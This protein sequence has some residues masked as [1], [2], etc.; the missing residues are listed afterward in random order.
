MGVPGQASGAH[1]GTAGGVN[2]GQLHP[3]DR[4]TAIAE[5]VVYRRV[6][7]YPPFANLAEDN[8]IAYQ[9]RFR[10]L[11][12]A[13]A[14]AATLP[15]Q[16]MPFSQPTI[17]I[18]RTAA[19]FRTDDVGLPVGRN[20]LDIFAAFFVR[21]GGNDSIDG[22]QTPTLGSA[23]FGDARQPALF[24]GNGLFFDRGGNL[25]VTCQTL[26]ANVRVDIVV[27]CLEEWGP[28]RG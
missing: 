17:I 7:V 28:P 1:P 20:A 3:H 13:A 10:R 5:G 22:D 11:T 25:S 16:V 23:I 27:W 19:A 4:R 24:P 9:V 26:L 15:P 21:V 12:F 14:A 18:A 6:P 2:A 8:R